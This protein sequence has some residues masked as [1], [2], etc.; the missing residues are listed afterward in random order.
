MSSA[1]NALVLVRARHEG[2]MKILRSL[3]D[4]DQALEML[5]VYDEDIVTGILQPYCEKKQEAG[6]FSRAN[7][8]LALAMVRAAVH[9]K[10]PPPSRKG[11]IHKLLGRKGN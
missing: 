2:S 4:R 11:L 5:A 1:R 7:P 6:D 9:E 3:A 10:A 8:H